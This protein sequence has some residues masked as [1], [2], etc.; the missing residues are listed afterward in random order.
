MPTPVV[1]QKE[2]KGAAPTPF[3]S[4]L[5]CRDEDRRYDGQLPSDIS[6]SHEAATPDPLTSPS[7]ATGDRLSGRDIPWPYMITSA[8][9]PQAA[10][11][12]TGV[13]DGAGTPPWEDAR[14]GQ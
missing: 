1:V 10:T 7:A 8:P 5:A 4:H 6:L 12:L 11:A 3:P 13:Q 2:P 14:G 9:R